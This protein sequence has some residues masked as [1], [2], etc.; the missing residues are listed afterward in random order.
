[1]IQILA[2][3]KGT[4][5]TKRLIAMANE[6]CKTSDGHTVF[7]DDDKSHIYDLHYNI[8]F[9]ETNHFLTSSAAV[10][11]GFILGIL[12]QDRDIEK[13]YIDGINTIIKN[14][15]EDDLVDLIKRFEEVSAE[16]NVD[17]IMIMSGTKV[18]DIPEY[19]KKYII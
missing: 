12:S 4:G 10:F 8:R 7:I 17:F 13:I 5:K 19:A 2:G 11:F 1:M 3:E 14:S 16:S 6:S 15:T 9:V 18:E